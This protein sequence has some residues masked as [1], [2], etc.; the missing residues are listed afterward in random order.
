LVLVDLHDAGVEVSMGA[1]LARE[2]RDDVVFSG[3]VA[4]HWAPRRDLANRL[5]ARA[6]LMRFA[7]IHGD[8]SPFWS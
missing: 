5:V 4:L 8:L 2:P 1:N 6:S 3:V 7:Q